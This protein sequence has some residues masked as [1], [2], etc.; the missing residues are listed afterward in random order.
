MR[1][2]MAGLALAAMLAACGQPADTPRGKPAPEQ[3]ASPV[4]A[5]AAGA[6]PQCPPWRGKFD[7]DGPLWLQVARTRDGAFVQFSPRGVRRDPIT[8]ETAASV[9]IL[10]RAAQDWSSSDGRIELSYSKEILVYRFRCAASQFLLT[11]RR[12]LGSGETTV[13]A[14]SYPADEAAWRPISA[15]GPA[16][17]LWGPICN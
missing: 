14:E 11:E 2:G 9:R 3:P 17:I 13:H 10:H 12:F 8:C 6:A 4:P 15:G 7:P 5:T 1:K 16:G